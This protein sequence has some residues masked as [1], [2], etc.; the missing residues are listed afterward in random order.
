MPFTSRTRPP[1]LAELTLNVII[2]NNNK[3][4]ITII[5]LAVVCSAGLELVL[6]PVAPALAAWGKP[7]FK[8]PGG[9]VGGIGGDPSFPGPCPRAAPQPLPWGAFPSSSP[10]RDVAPGPVSS[11][12]CDLGKSVPPLQASV[13]PAKGRDEPVSGRGG[14]GGERRWSRVLGWA[15]LPTSENPCFP[16][17]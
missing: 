6:Y 11:L 8:F 9:W 17:C 7:G 13:F 14:C 1:N 10:A 3:L 16:G 2:S 12:A 5:I 4:P 15:A